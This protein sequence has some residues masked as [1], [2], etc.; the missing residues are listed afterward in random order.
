MNQKVLHR[1]G[2]DGFSSLKL[3]GTVERELIPCATSTNF[4]SAPGDWF[5]SGW[6][7]LLSLLYALRISWSVADFETVVDHMTGGQGRR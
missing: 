6:Y 2:G 5:L 7:F 4:P 1:L 3:A